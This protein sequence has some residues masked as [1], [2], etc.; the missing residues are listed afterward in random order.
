M[1]RLS[2]KGSHGSLHNNQTDRLTQKD[3]DKQHYSHP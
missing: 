3:Q 2:P 1:M